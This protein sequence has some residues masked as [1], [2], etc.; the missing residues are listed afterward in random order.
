MSLLQLIANGA[1][2]ANIPNSDN[3]HVLESRTLTFNNDFC[4]INRYADLFTPKKIICYNCS[5]DFSLNLIELTI[6]GNTII[7]INDA[8]FLDFIGFSENI[9]INGTVNKVY[10]LDKTKLFFPVKLIALHYHEVRIR[11]TK[12]GNC[13]TIKLNGV[14]DFLST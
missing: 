9:N 6:G 12:S 7:I 14:Y 11:I 5:E 4:N 2:E 1:F 13:N 8:N 3:R 10:H